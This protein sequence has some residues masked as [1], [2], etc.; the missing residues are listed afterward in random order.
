LRETLAGLA[1]IHEWGFIH[2]DV[3]AVNILIDE[4]KHAR[5]ADFGLTTI[6]TR[7]D[8]VAL[9]FAAGEEKSTNARWLAPE[10]LRGMPHSAAGDMYAFGCVVLEVS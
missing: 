6:I 5:L 9:N 1:F 8:S 2:G 3:R 4:K 10:F 7:A